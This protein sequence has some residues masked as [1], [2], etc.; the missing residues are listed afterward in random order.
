MFYEDHMKQFVNAN[1][2]VKDTVHFRNSSN[3]KNTIGQGGGGNRVDEGEA[4][5]AL[6][7][8]AKEPLEGRTKCI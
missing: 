8:I 2:F 4:R 1:T 5:Q 6:A 3:L 7:V